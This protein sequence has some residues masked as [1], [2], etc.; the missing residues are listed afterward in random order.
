MRSLSIWKL[1][2]PS[3]VFVDYQQTIPGFARTNTPK[4]KW[5]KYQRIRTLSNE[6]E[7]ILPAY[8]EM[9]GHFVLLHDWEIICTLN[10]TTTRYLIPRGQPTD[11]ASIP[12]IIHS[13]ISPL[14]NSVYSAVL[15]DYLYR[16]PDDF[17]ANQTTRKDADRIFYFGMKA[18]G[19][20]RTMAL[21]MYWG[22][23]LGGTRSYI[24]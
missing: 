1:I 11:F 18:C 12:R 14:S 4:K 24:R 6:D 16:N 23:R 17:V 15:H 13:V 8:N 2:E 9:K 5:N 22:V 3:P 7:Y 19:V 21:L 20:S 10:Q